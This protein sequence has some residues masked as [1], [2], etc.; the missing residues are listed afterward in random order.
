MSKAVLYLVNGLGVEKRDSAGIYNSQLMPNFDKLISKNFF[1][2][3]EATATNYKSGYQMF[4]T[5]SDKFPE[6][7]F[8]DNLLFSE[9]IKENYNF[10]QLKNITNDVS[11]S[12]HVFIKITDGTVIEELA[13]FFKMLEMPKEKNV[14][15]HVILTQNG[16]DTYKKVISSYNSL[17]FKSPIQVKF[18]SIFGSNLLDNPNRRNDLVG[19]AKLLYKG[20]G[21]KWNEPEKKLR[22]LEESRYSPNDINAFYVSDVRLK[23]NDT[24]MFFNHSEEEYDEFINILKTPISFVSNGLDLNSINYISLFPLKTKL[25]IPSLFGKVVAPYSLAKAATDNNFKVLVIADNENLNDINY[26]LNGL[27]NV[28]CPNIQYMVVDEQ[29]LNNYQAMNIVLNDPTFDLIIINTRIDNIDNIDLLKQKLSI[30]DQN[31]GMVSEL[32]YGSYPFIVSSL[33]GIKKI[34]KD[35]NGQNVYVNF[36]GS[37]PMIYID[38]N[39]NKVNYVLNSGNTNGMLCTA[40]KAYKH[41]INCNTLFKK[42]GFIQKMIKK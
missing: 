20:F 4:S 25:N 5:G 34:V 6:Y 18:G 27:S 11:K 19:V 42:K 29:A 28:K 41:T 24:V 12:F 30:I 38:K 39:Y 36:Y 22:L 16:F 14:F 3:L 15:I 2:Q 40:I 32:C 13:D 17:R 33:F 35:A 10:K 31:I 8:L 26:M 37:V 21:E 23:E 1:T 7:P 9:S